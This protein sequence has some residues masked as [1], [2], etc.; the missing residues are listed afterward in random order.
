[1]W[2]WCLCI[3]VYIVCR[4]LVEGNVCLG[5]WFGN[6]FLVTCFCCF[7][8]EKCADGCGV[9]DCELKLIWCYFKLL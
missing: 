9:G 8:G 5:G 2:H 1:M 4:G 3:G 6:F 7:S